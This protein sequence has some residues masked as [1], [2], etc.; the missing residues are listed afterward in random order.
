MKINFKITKLTKQTT[1]EKYSIKLLDIHIG[2]FLIQELM[3]KYIEQ[4]L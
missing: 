3:Q 1:P 4:K 2:L